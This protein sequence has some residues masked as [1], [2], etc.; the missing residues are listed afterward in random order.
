MTKRYL[1]PLADYQRIY[2]VIYSVLEASGNAHTHRACAFFAYVGAQIL[3]EHYRLK[4][5]ISMGCM[6]MMVDEASAKVVVY[7]RQEGDEWVYD[8]DGFHAW[9]ECDGWL[10]DFMAPIMGAAYAEDGADFKVP[11]KMLQKRLADR[12]P[13][14]LAIQHQGDFFCADD[15]AI[16][17]D[18]LDSQ[19]LLFRDLVG[20]CKTWFRRPPKPLQAI[21]MAGNE[22]FAA[23]PLILRAPIIVGAW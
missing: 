13:H 14:L 4:A 6:G 19:G 2:Q 1:L 5:T 16:A 20:I 10:I 21:G 22:G 18:V 17:S 3:R 15:P 12:K 11:S 7:G 8:A 23:K 9:V